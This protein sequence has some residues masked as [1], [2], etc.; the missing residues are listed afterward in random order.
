MRYDPQGSDHLCQ[1]HPVDGR[2]W[3]GLAEGQTKRDME[4]P[5]RGKVHSLNDRRPAL[6]V[7][8]GAGRRR[9]R[10]HRMRKR[11]LTFRM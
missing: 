10:D 3:L 4:A 9:V 8:G 1:T 5:N 11:V 6:R 2:A 7:G